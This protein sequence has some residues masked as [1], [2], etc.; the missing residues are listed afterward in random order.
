MDNPEPK[1]YHFN[2]PWF[3]VN[4][5]MDWEALRIAREQKIGLGE[6]FQMVLDDP[7]LMEKCQEEGRNN[8]VPMPPAG[9]W[10]P[11]EAA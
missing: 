1:R 2:A 5:A 10:T 6:A 8:V 3:A 4:R 9:D 7:V 11:P